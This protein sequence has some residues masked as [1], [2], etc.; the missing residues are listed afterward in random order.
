MPRPKVEIHTDRRV[1]TYLDDDAVDAIDEL[2]AAE[3][4]SRAAIVRRALIADLTRRSRAA[5]GLPEHVEDP[6]T[7]QRVAALLGDGM[8]TPSSGDEDADLT[9]TA[10]NGD[11]AHTSDRPAGA[12]R[13]G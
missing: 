13:S 3:G 8:S 12:L 10:T 2:A 7:L 5:Q 9:H 11:V 1:Y 6:S 4:T